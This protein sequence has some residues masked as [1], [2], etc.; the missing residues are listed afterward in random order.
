M[1]YFLNLFGLSTD[2]KPS[3]EQSRDVINRFGDQNG[4]NGSLPISSPQT[5]KFESPKAK[6]I[7]DTDSVN[8][9]RDGAIRA[10]ELNHDLDATRRR[11]EEEVTI[12]REKLREMQHQQQQQQ[13]QQRTVIIFKICY[14]TELF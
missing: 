3:P 8:T 7:P 6:N 9:I 10:L 4:R 12:R 2:T 11:V 13:Q 14:L 1:A 5:M